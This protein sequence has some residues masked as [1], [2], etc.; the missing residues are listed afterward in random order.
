[1]IQKMSGT[2]R[3]QEPQSGGLG[4]GLGL[5]WAALE[6]GDGR[7]REQD[8]LPTSRLSLRSVPLGGALP[9]PGL[10]RRAVS[11]VAPGQGHPG[12]L[13]APGLLGTAPPTCPET[14]AAAP[15]SVALRTRLA[16]ICLSPVS[17]AS[18]TWQGHVLG[19]EQPPVFPAWPSARLS[20]ASQSVLPGQDQHT[21]S[22]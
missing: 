5:C 16:G 11:G 15:D 2:L 4:A 18:P 9:S 17:A 1:M 21:L 14:Q 3:G 6:L 12:R 10:R 7:C 22:A 13:A 8:H 20:G 19:L